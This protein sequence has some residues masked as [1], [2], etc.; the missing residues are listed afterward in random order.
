MDDWTKLNIISQF[1]LSDLVKLLEAS[2]YELKKG[3]M[4]VVLPDPFRGMMGAE[5]FYGDSTV[6]LKEVFTLNSAL[7]YLPQIL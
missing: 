3:V 1:V 2:K 7:L 5:K 6:R 4:L